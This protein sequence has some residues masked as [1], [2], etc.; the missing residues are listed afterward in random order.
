MCTYSLWEGGDFGGIV[1]EEL[2]GIGVRVGILFN[3][4]VLIIK[5]ILLHSISLSASSLSSS[6]SA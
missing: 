5:Y 1:E 4:M 2:E 6:Y 3:I